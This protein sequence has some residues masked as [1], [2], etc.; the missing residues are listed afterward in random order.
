M[1]FVQSSDI[2][3]GRSRHRWLQREYRNPVTGYATRLYDV[4][5]QDDEISQIHVFYH[6]DVIINGRRIRGDKEGILRHDSNQTVWT[7][8]IS[9][10]SERYRLT[11]KV[12]FDAFEQEAYNVLGKAEWLTPEWNARAISM[13]RDVTRPMPGEVNLTRRDSALWL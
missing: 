5:F 2:I 10:D 11:T 3:N 7:C 4:T 8:Q 6:F 9:R 1:E 12:N 13:V